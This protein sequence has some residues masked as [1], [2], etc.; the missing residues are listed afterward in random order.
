LGAVNID[1]HNAND[2]LKDVTTKVLELRS[3]QIS[4]ISTMVHHL[5]DYICL[6]IR[7]KSFLIPLILRRRFQSN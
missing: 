5:L 1:I 4:F 6:G 7:M 3:F 2:L